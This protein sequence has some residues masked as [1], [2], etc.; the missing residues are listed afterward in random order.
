MHFLF[1][2]DFLR[3]FFQFFAASRGLIPSLPRALRRTV[4]E[5][6]AY[7]IAGH[8]DNLDIVWC[9]YSVAN[10]SHSTLPKSQL[11]H[12]FRDGG[13]SLQAVLLLSANGIY[14]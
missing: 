7:V 1:F 4:W 12:E 6:L 8:V 9:S 13:I 5:P 2:V 14:V 10:T 3:Y 11:F